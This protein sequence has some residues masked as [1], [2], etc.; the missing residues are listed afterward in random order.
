MSRSGAEG[1][2]RH[3][4]LG[5][6]RGCLQEVRRGGLAAGTARQGGARL[7]TGGARLGKA[8]GAELAGEARSVGFDRVGLG[9]AGQAQI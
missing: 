4:R 2:G 3:G 9:K 1:L 7:R 5:K 6:T 8:G